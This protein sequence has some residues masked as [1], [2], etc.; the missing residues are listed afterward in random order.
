M[1][2]QRSPVEAKN[3]D[4]NRLGNTEVPC[5]LALHFVVAKQPGIS[6]RHI[7]SPDHIPRT[8][9]FSKPTKHNR[10][11]WVLIQSGGPSKRLPKM[12]TPK[13]EE[14]ERETEFRRCVSICLLLA[15]NSMTAGSDEIPERGKLQT[16]LT[17]SSD[18]A[19]MQIVQ[20][21]WHKHVARAMCNQHVHACKTR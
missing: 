7:S 4:V 5:W 8:Y 12:G 18:N 14:G 6:Q 19:C 2:R 16:K 3:K 21:E 15:C 11:H 13:Q 9:A 10:Q 1:R 17:V 20:I